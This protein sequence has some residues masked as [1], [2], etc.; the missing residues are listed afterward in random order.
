ML[1]WSELAAAVAPLGHTITHLILEGGV[2]HADDGQ[3]LLQQALPLVQCI[4]IMVY[5][6]SSSSCLSDLVLLSPSLKQMDLDADGPSQIWLCDMSV[7]CVAR[8][9]RPPGTLRVQ[10]PWLES[11]TL[12]WAKQLWGRLVGQLVGPASV[13]VTDEGGKN[14]LAD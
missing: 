7:S 2:G 3:E 4:S 11:E 10:L 12:Q 9:A 14:L 6:D 13:V 5:S 1:L 8:A